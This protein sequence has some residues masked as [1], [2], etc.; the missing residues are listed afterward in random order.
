MKSTICL[1]TRYNLPAVFS[2]VS[3]EPGGVMVSALARDTEGRGFDSRSFHFQ[4]TT[5]GKLFT[6]THVPLSPSSIIWYPSRG[7]DALRLGR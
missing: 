4:V 6:H 5:L 2:L 7:G 1:H 3:Q